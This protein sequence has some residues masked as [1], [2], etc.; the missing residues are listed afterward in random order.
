MP[1]ESR[2]LD[3]RGRPIKRSELTREIATAELTGVRSVWNHESVANGLN[4]D[5]LASLLR[6]A[7]EGE[8]NGYLTLAEE[9][10]DRDLHYF[11]VLGTRKMAVSGIEPTVEA[12]S[13]S[14]GDKKLA[15]EV[16]QIIRRPEFGELADDMLDALGKGYSAIE[17][18]WDRSESQWD[19]ADYKW[20][21]QRFFRF[22]RTT[23]T[24]L[25]LLDEQDSFNGIAL[26]AYKFIVHVPRIKSGLPIRR[27]FARLASI[28]YMCKAFTI[29]D[30]L[31]FA[32]VF[33]MPL[34]LG[35]Y[36]KGAT[37][38]D[39]QTLINA[40]A[41]L[42]TDAAAVLP[43][44]M[45]IDFEEAAGSDSK[46]LFR[47]LA[48]YLD[49]QMS[50]AIL[51]QTG[52]TEGTPGRLGNDDA[53][54]DVRIDI[55]RADATQLQNTIN[56]LLIK[57]YIDLNHG[58]QKSYPRVLLGVREPED[59]KALSDALGN[60][61]PQGLRVAQ[62]WVRDK[63]GAPDPE[64]GEEILGGA[65]P[66]APTPPAGDIG[67]ANNRRHDC[68]SCGVSLNREDPNED[69]I[70]ELTDQAVDNDWEEQL[71][72]VIDPIQR[73]ADESESFEEF[74]Q[75]LPELY[76]ELDDTE[77]VRR[78]ALRTFQARGLGDATDDIEEV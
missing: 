76:G 45:R 19:P 46:G 48:E 23:G 10:E 3:H 61:V 38:N 71:G 7:I 62:G 49:K 35:R 6:S 51:G 77:I 13:D 18:M 5:R 68:P 59:I 30:W 44:T 21:D 11:S 4:P 31:A 37:S 60:L 28:A 73:L 25:R 75:R 22:D 20:R 74:L 41:N 53:M 16:E 55:K 33:G 57:T 69:E 8:H 54:G 36:G 39:I 40:V 29:T 72:P 14:A 43:D 58:P 67:T 17:I 32:E 70:D 26:P 9:M 1:D 24:E 27:G 56:R 12:A 63:L 64:D 50:K 52:T 15:E 78:L 66:A 2:I 65:P 34:R 42:G 47:E